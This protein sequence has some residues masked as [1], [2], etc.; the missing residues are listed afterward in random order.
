MAIALNCAIVTGRINDSLFFG[1]DISSL[2]LTDKIRIWHYAFPILD[3]MTSRDDICVFRHKAV[4]I[5]MG[6]LSLNVMK[7]RNSVLRKFMYIQKFL[8]NFRAYM[9]S[10]KFIHTPPP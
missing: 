7:V 2:P 1:K 8:I 4:I 6:S 9:E 3:S 5:N 10:P